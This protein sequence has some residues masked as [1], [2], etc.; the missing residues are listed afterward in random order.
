MKS[1]WVSTSQKTTLRDAI[2]GPPACPDC[3]KNQLI[4]F[5]L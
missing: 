5:L 3:G 1:A 4:T 2:A